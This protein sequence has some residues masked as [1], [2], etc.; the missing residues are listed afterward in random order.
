MWWLIFFPVID[1]DSVLEG[2]ETN[3]LKRANLY[4]P[5]QRGCAAVLPVQL[6]V[7]CLNS[8]SPLASSTRCYKLITYQPLQGCHFD[9]FCDLALGGG[10]GE[11]REVW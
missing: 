4:Y 6:A 7:L 5:A 8:T 10:R 11:S 9:G 2:G 1:G 3:C